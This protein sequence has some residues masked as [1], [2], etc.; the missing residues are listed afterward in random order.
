MKKNFLLLIIALLFFT[1]IPTYSIDIQNLLSQIGFNIFAEKDP[2]T[3]ITKILE[4]Q[5]NYANKQN[6]KKLQQLYS[7]DYANFDGIKLDEYI[8]SIQDTWKIY[9]KLNYTTTINYINVNGDYATVDATDTTNGTTKKPYENIEGKGVL[10]AT[11]K[12]LY[13]FKKEQGEWKIVA[14]MVYSEKTSIK[15][16]SAKEIEIKM[17]APECV[18][19]ENEYNVKIS[20][21]LPDGTGLI[22]SIASENIQ[23]PQAINREEVFRPMK[24]SGELERVLIANNEG[25]NEIA[26]ASVALAK[27][28]VDEN[29]RINIKVDGVAFVASRINVIPKRV[30]ANE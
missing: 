11:S 7:K 2:K 9:D 19:A 4:K 6:Y 26:I 30:K 25:K 20:A 22:A 24:Q 18:S 5:Q 10:N 17:D 3:E 28:V 14:D 27:A 12:T 23:Y 16:G 15:Y 1:T 13:Y 8:S 29:S 21:D